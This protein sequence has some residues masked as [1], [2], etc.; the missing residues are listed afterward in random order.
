MIDMIKVKARRVASVADYHFEKLLVFLQFHQPLEL[1][2]FGREGI[3]LELKPTLLKTASDQIQSFIQ[4]PFSSSS[5][6]LCSWNLRFGLLSIVLQCI[7]S[8]T[9]S[10]RAIWRDSIPLTIYPI[11]YCASQPSM[12]C[13]SEN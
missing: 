2:F 10:S 9:S 11:T 12:V 1:T 6:L 4:C 13:S 5:I 7:D 8:Y 3:S